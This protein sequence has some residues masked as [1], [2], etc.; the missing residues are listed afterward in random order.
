MDEAS[1]IPVRR[2][3]RLDSSKGDMQSERKSSGSFRWKNPWVRVK[4]LVYSSTTASPGFFCIAVWSLVFLILYLFSQ[5]WIMRESRFCDHGS[6]IHVRK[7]SILSAFAACIFA[8]SGFMNLSATLL[9]SAQ[10]KRQCASFVFFIEV[11][12]CATNLSL[13]YKVFPDLKNIDGVAF[14]WL[15]IF[16][17]SFTT[18]T[19]LI[20]LSGLGT[21]MEEQLVMD[22]ELTRRAI[23]YDELLLLSGFLAMYYTGA[24]RVFFFLL[25]VTFYLKMCQLIG[26]IVN[27]CIANSGTASEV[28]IL[29]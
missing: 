9:Q 7:E 1:K 13:F 16:Q 5:S 2:I 10:K 8:V 21:S 14:D 26:L 19:M 20:I 24:F 15:H 18:P 3:S 4:E 23:F 25:A 17:W 12:A 22:W 27:L 28:H 6:L 11:V 29:R